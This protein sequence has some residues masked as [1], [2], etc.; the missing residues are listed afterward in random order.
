MSNT[1]KMLNTAAVAERLGLHMQT[2]LAMIE[3][4]EFE[5]VVYRFGKVY[6]FDADRLEEWVD[7]RAVT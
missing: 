4:G 1:T 5:G 3:R 6:R 7:S 2:I